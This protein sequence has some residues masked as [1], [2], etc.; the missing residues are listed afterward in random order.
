MHQSNSLHKP[1]SNKVLDS[2][3]DTKPRL[4]KW[5]LLLQEFDLEIKDR[6][7]TENQIADHLLRLEADAST[8]TKRAITE[9]FPDEHQLMIQHTQM[10]K[11][12][13]LL[14]YQILLIT[15]WVD[16]YHLIW[17][18]SKRRDFSMILETISGII[19]IYTR[20]AQTMWSK[21]LYRIKK[22]HTYCIHAM[23]QHMKDILEAT[24]Q[25]SKFYNQVI[26]RPLF[27]M[28]LMSLL[29]VL[30]SAKTQGTYLKSMKCH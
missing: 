16:Y 2:K 28:M 24:E 9:A 22:F 23:L 20:Y 18:I 14:W 11:Q 5:I 19:S 6:K 29:N 27:L 12:S 26:I 7:G 13:G 1:C 25:Q 17:I 3:K 8:L 15:W 10:L 4:I 30:T 21:N